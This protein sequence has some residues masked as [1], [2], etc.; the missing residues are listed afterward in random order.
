MKN[1]ARGLKPSVAFGGDT[2]LTM[3][4]KKSELGKNWGIGETP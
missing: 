4:T 1:R 3:M 2:T